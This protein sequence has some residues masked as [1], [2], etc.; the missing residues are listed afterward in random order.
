MTP[1]KKRRRSRTSLAV[2]R[3]V[4]ADPVVLVHPRP[5][6]GVRGPVVFEAVVWRVRAARMLLVAVNSIRLPLGIGSPGL[7]GCRRAELTELKE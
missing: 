3:A 1:A 5:R 4:L 7:H 2:L 6:E